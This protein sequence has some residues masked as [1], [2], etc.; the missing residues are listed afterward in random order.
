MSWILLFLRTGHFVFSYPRQPM[1]LPLVCM[2]RIRD[3]V[4]GYYNGCL[5]PPCK[6]I[7]QIVQFFCIGQG[8]IYAG[9]HADQRHLVVNIGGCAQISFLRPGHCLPLWDWRCSPWCLG[10]LDVSWI[11]WDIFPRSCSHL[12]RVPVLF[13]IGHEHTLPSGIMVGVSS[14]VMSSKDSGGFVSIG[15]FLL[16]LALHASWIS[17]KYLS[18]CWYQGVQ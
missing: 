4:P 6:I 8:T 2:E 9:C 16:S 1:D 5:T 12:V 13:K 18:S 11:H 14:E 7:W 10:S 15:R 3:F 17:V